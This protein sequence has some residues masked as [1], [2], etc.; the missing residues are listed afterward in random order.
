M[1][2]SAS[3]VFRLVKSQ[4]PPS[5][6]APNMTVEVL[7]EGAVG[8]VAGAVVGVVV[9]GAFVVVVVAGA[10]VV[11]VVAAIGAAVVGVVVELAAGVVVVVVTAGRVV[12]VVAERFQGRADAG[13]AV[14]ATITPAVARTDAARARTSVVP[15]VPCRAGHRE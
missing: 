6:A 12:V 5:V 1:P 15:G 4:G 9:V 7:V 3:I 10:L 13:P 2:A 8:A 14:A 11:V